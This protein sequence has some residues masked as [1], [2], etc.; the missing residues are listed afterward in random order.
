MAGRHNHHFPPLGIMR[1]LDQQ[2]DLVVLDRRLPGQVLLERAV[3]EVDPADSRLA[4]QATAFEQAAED[5][6]R[7][8]TRPPQLLRRS[9]D[10]P[11]DALSGCIGP[12]ISNEPDGNIL[13]QLY[14]VAAGEIHPGRY[15]AAFGVP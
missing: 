11:D 1:I 9:R 8:R 14:L 6:W 5:F 3:N 10:L 7:V 13:Q 4:E 2:S 15:D 12:A